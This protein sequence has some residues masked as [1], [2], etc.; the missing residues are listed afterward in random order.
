MFARLT[1]MK[2]LEWTYQISRLSPYKVCCCYSKAF[3]EC[4]LVGNHMFL[5]SLQKQAYQRRWWGAISLY[6][7]WF[8]DKLFGLK[9]LR[10]SIYEWWCRRKLVFDDSECEPWR[11]TLIIISQHAQCWCK[12][13]WWRFHDVCFCLRHCWW[14]GDNDDEDHG[15]PA[16]VDHEVT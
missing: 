4:E 12:S 16:L 11:R 5:F 10:W 7:V 15:E 1:G 13:S 6:Q 14:W 2:M 8:H 9:V 3:S